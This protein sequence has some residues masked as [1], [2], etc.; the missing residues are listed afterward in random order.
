MMEMLR[1]NL[2][3]QLPPYLLAKKMPPALCELRK[4]AAGVFR[5]HVCGAFGSKDALSSSASGDARAVLEYE[6]HFKQTRFIG[7]GATC[8]DWLA[9]ASLLTVSKDPLLSMTSCPASDSL[10]RLAILQTA[11]KC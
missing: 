3:Q 11:V 7:N 4:R 10:G 8:M 2:L 5:V 1:C 9:E 6:R